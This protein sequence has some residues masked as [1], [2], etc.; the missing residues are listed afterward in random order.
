MIFGPFNTPENRQ[1]MLRVR[2]E[3]GNTTYMPILVEVFTPIPTLENVSESGNVSGILDNPIE[4]EPIEI[5]RIRSSE[6]PMM[7]NTGSILTDTEG[8]FSSGSYRTPEN[9][10]VTTGQDVFRILHSGIFEN[11]PA[12]Y[13][14]RVSPADATKPL[15]INVYNTQK[16][17]AYQQFFSLPNSARIFQKTD[18]NASSTGNLLVSTHAQYRFA[19][20]DYND[21]KIP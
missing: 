2:D 17:L 21:P 6:Y 19:N 1:M 4:N 8:K 20:A 5:F 12:G 7:V 3:F 10:T 14:I 18:E 11:V 9:I 13:E 15:S 16:I